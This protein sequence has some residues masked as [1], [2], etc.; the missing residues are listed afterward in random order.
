MSG[1]FRYDAVVVGAGPNGLAAALRLSRAGL[2]TLLVE[3]NA[4]L[5]GGLRSEAATLPGFI[6][7]R[8]A[9]VH[10]LAV[11]SP[12]FRAMGLNEGAIEWLRSPTPLAHVLSDGRAV[13]LEQSIDDTAARLGPDGARYR[14]LFSPFVERFEHLV[15]DVLAPLHWPA[16]PFLFARF[17]LSAMRSVQ[18]LSHALFRG[19][20]APALLAGIAAHAMVPLDRLVT[21]SFALVLGA[22]GHAVGWPVARGGSS[23]VAAAL[24]ARLTAAGVDIMLSERVRDIGDLPKA[25]A[26]LFDVSPRALAS[27]AG[28]ALTSRYRRRLAS[29]RYGPGVCK[30]DWALAGPIPWRDRACERA[31]TVHLGGSAD[32]IARAEATV[33]GGR[34]AERPFVLLGQPSVVDPT[35]APAGKHTAWAY[36]HVPHDCPVDVHA[37][38]EAEVERAAPGFR[39]LIL[40]RA[41]LSAAEV[42]RYDEN[43]VGGDISGGVSDLWQLFFRPVVKADPYET[44]APGVYICSA[45]TPPGGGVHGMCGYWAAE[46]ALVNTFGRARSPL[47]HRHRKEARARDQLAPR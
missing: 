21:A 47:H 15:E 17:G 2:S 29:F 45:S 34:L 39:D 9:S 4:Q 12:F 36:C 44:S 23:A 25:R 19:A 18:G 16:H 6:H 31:I 43:C 35:R 32:D 38:I 11:A 41:S 40:A 13:C 37:T 26:Y 28:S 5:G 20:E 8:C 30:V 1:P 22:A 3:G 7:D 42:S 10:P 24:A 27:I 46:S 14:R 33:N